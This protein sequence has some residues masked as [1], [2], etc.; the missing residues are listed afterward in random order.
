MTDLLSDQAKQAI[1]DGFKCVAD[2]FYHTPITVDLRLGTVKKPF[3]EGY[4]TTYSPINTVCRMETSKASGER[5]INVKDSPKGK[6]F[7]DGYKVF[8][9]KESFDVLLAGRTVNPE[10]DRVI[11]DGKQYEIRMFDISARFSNIG[12]LQYEMDLTQR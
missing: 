4:T 3:G 9:W 5:Y 12:P 7:Q 10:T 1:R 8:L 11:I 6:D 2:T